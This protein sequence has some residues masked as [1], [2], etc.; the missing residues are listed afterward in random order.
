MKFLAIASMRD[1][2]TTLPPALTRQL[3]E[4]TM[5]EMNQQ[6]KAGKILD[7]YLIPGWNRVVV[8]SEAKSAEEE[9]QNINRTPIISFYNIELYPLADINEATK[10][11]IESLKAAEK[12]MPVPPK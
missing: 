9:Y 2:A 10:V 12:M 8:I 7:M 5:V 4:A 3:L 11:A 6:K 1:T